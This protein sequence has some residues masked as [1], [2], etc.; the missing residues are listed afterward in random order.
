MKNFIKLSKDPHP[1]ACDLIASWPG[2]GN[3]SL[4]VAQYIREK[5]DAEEIGAIE[6]FSFFEPIGVMVKNNI[7]EAPQFPESKIYYW[8]NAEYERDLLLF[9]GDE[10]PSVKGYDMANAVLDICE[11]LKVKR[12]Y[13]LAAAIAK[14]HH[15]EMPKV[16]GAATN[17]KLVE[18]L[19]QY[20]V[21][22]RGAVQIAGLNG[23]FLGVAKE[24]GMDGI[25][26]LGE[27]P[28]Y[29]TR[30]P[31]PKSALAIL[32]V[33]SVMLHIDID[34]A[35]LSVAANK[36]DEEMKRMAAEAMGEFITSY[37]KPVW[38]QDEYEEEED[39][40]EDDDDDDDEEY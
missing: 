24:R 18:E 30:I 10:Q 39:D 17:Q 14:I 9:I 21:V 8:R 35:D 11:K 1:K 7:I 15:T 6:P 40:D 37:T 22:L 4:I 23:L 25:C 36:A 20:E 28:S 38:P 19:K 16:W 29:T 3:V 27:V 33:L 12:V 13:T 31:N 2:I 32:N 5:L 26:L 34:T